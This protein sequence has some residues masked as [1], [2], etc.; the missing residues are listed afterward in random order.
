MKQ[1]ATK[2]GSIDKPTPSPPGGGVEEAL[3]LLLERKYFKPRYTVG[4]LSYTGS[5]GCRH[6]LCDTLEPPSAHTR[7]G[8][9]LRYIQFKKGLG[10][11]AVPLGAYEVRM[12]ESRRFG[13]RLPRLVGVPGF[14]GVLI[15]EGNY[16]KD[17]AGCILPGWNRRRGMVCNSRS[18]LAKVI[19]LMNEA[20]GNGKKVTLAIFENGKKTTKRQKQQNNKTTTP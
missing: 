16:P 12:A 20:E 8:S 18:A 19:E 15:H 14:R 4:T 13:R 2:V 5:D 9:S 10:F 3:N 7:Q 11:R 6:A 1:T 17:T